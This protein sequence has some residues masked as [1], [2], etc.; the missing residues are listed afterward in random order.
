MLCL[1]PNATLSSACIA[2]YSSGPAPGHTTF[3]PNV[4][5]NSSTFVVS[6]LN[7]SAVNQLVGRQLNSRNVLLPKVLNCSGTFHG[8]P[9]LLATPPGE[10]QPPLISIVSRQP[11]DINFP[12][13]YYQNGSINLGSLPITQCK[14]TIFNTPQCYRKRFIRFIPSTNSSRLGGS[15]YA[16]PTAVLLSNLCTVQQ[17]NND[18]CYSQC[19]SYGPGPNGTRV[20]DG[21]Y[22]LCKQKVYL[23]LPRNWRGLCAPITLSN[24]TFVLV[25]QNKSVR[26]KRSIDQV[27]Q[28]KENKPFFP[29][30]NFLKTRGQDVPDEYRL[31]SL[32]QKFG[33]S[34]VPSLGVAHAFLLLD[35]VHYHVLQLTDLTFNATE[36]IREELTALRLMTLQNRMVLDLLT[37]SQGGVC[38]IVGDA[39]CTW[40]PENDADGHSIAMAVE[41]LK[42]LLDDEKKDSVGIASDWLTDMLSGLPIPVWLSRMLMILFAVLMML[43]LA[44]CCIVPLVQRLAR[45]AVTGTFLQHHLLSREDDEADWD[46]KDPFTMFPLPHSDADSTV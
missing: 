31:N 3:D 37:A 35:K 4:P 29:S 5:V 38:A 27:R 26:A 6:Q 21:Y 36:A 25:P 41:G 45:R 13:C 12:I 44:L 10:T 8:K 14:L 34:I 43:V 7:A 19:D 28:E 40:I 23:Y 46:E 24:E 15:A 9:W 42:T 39:C 17:P 33:W 2:A 16:D 32:G 18:S 11:Q 30:K 22:W 20:I 1:H